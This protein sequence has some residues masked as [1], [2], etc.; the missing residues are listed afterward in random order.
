MCANI[1]RNAA[2]I[3]TTIASTAKMPARP[4]ASEP[5]VCSA[6]WCG[7][8]MASTRQREQ[9]KRERNCNLDRGIDKARFAP[10]EMLHEIG[11]ERPTN[12]ACE[13]TEQ[14]YAP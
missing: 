11:A 5:A 6:I 8:D 14:R 13:T 7:G 4:A 3:V 1:A 10:S 9:M 12:G 2:P